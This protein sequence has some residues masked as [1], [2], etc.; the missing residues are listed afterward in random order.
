MGSAL[1]PL[2]RLLVVIGLAITVIGLALTAGVS[3]AWFGRLP[4]D[5]IIR[6]EHAVF[7]LPL[8]TCLVLSAVISLVLW[9]VNRFRS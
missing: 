6:R 4:G 5:L 2:G 3:F 7:Y 8:T 9:L 1:Q